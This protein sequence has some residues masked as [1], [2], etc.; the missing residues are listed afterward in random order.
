MMFTGNDG[1]SYYKRCKK[2][3]SNSGWLEYEITKEEYEEA[4]KRIMNELK[5][6]EQVNE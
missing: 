4:I 1:V 2:Y 6:E 5:K 3:F